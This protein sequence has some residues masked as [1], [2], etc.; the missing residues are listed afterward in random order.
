MYLGKLTNLLM[1]LA[2]LSSTLACAQVCTQ[3]LATTKAAQAQND[4]IRTTLAAAK[5]ACE[6]KLVSATSIAASQ[7]SCACKNVTG[8]LSDRDIFNARFTKQI[9]DVKVQY[10]A[11][12]GGDP[13]KEQ[14]LV[15]DLYANYM[16]AKDNMPCGNDLGIYPNKTISLVTDNVGF[17]CTARTQS[18]SSL[19]NLPLCSDTAASNA[20]KAVV[21]AD[22]DKLY[23]VRSGDQGLSKQYACAQ[24]PVEEDNNSLT[25]RETPPCGL[26]FVKKFQDNGT[27]YQNGVTDQTVMAE[28]KKSDCYT[29]ITTEGLEI[30]HIDIETSSSQ[31]ANTGTAANKTFKTLSGDRADKIENDVFKKIPGFENTTFNENSAGK[32]KDGTSGPCPYHYSDTAPYWTRRTDITAKEL[33]ENKYVRAKIFYKNKITPLTGKGNQL[34]L[35]CSTVGFGCKNDGVYTSD[36][37]K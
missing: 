24:K 25:S 31:L 7:H 35:S 1:C 15:D 28:I 3:D 23:Q 21:S 8:A 12:T 18:S 27:G 5:K 22:L 11:Q 4:L 30:D 33:D 2:G 16:K 29:R 32:N 13:D 36:S 34:H 20:A 14:K 26:N 9:L 37:F 17:F 10:K 6:D 19:V